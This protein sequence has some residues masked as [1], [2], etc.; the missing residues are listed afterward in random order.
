M[1]S[2]MDRM[3]ATAPAKGHLD[4]LDQ[5][6]GIAALYVVIHHAVINIAIPNSNFHDPLFRMLQMLSGKGHFAVDVFI[7]LSGYCLML[8]LVSKREFG[9]IQLFYLRRTLRIVLPYY[10]AMLLSLML[11]YF[12]I[13]S[14][15]G[16]HWA[17]SLPVTPDGI[18]RHMLLIHQWFPS[19][20][21]T[22]NHVFWSIGVEYQIYFLFPFFFY[23]TRNYSPVGSWLA[24]T[25]AGYTCWLASVA[26]FS[27]GAAPAGESFV[28]CGLFF[29]GMVAA[30][31]SFA[32]K[33]DLPTYLVVV[34]ENSRLSVAVVAMIVVMVALIGNRYRE[35]MPLLTQSLFV[36]V[37]TSLIFF[38]KARG[39]ILF[40]WNKTISR[41]L[42]WLGV[43]G[44][45]LYLIH[46]PILELVWLYV[47]Q[48]IG[49]STHGQQAVAMIILGTAA[50]VLVAW[51]FYIL[52][53]SPSHRLSKSVKVFSFSEQR[54]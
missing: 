16:T 24:I 35:A 3:T 21:S 36:G 47:V 11:I 26:I 45:S 54:T 52:V 14:D 50:S 48:P 7:V 13:G 39:K 30:K 31:Y 18:V 17:A 42:N 8:P 46:A 9:S 43:I 32:D 49:L 20:I 40:P 2:D 19:D 28:Y 4:W 25:L 38:L 37:A 34:S 10:A 12:L 23:L 1:A 29:L 22:I 53:E 5:V 33:K 51:F 6:R 44:F 41:M 15:S 27:P